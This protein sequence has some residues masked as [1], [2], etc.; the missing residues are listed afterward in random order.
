MLLIRDGEARTATS[1]FAQLL[2]SDNKLLAL[3]LS[4]ASTLTSA[5]K[6]TLWTTADWLLP[7]ACLL[8]QA[9]KAQRMFCGCAHCACRKAL[10]IRRGPLAENQVH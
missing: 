6:L 7:I 1:T 10:G 5:A 3:Q 4:V 8:R 2:S 9:H